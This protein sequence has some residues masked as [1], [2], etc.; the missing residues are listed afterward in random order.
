M[1]HDVGVVRRGFQGSLI[2]DIGFD[3]SRARVGRPR[4]DALIQ[5]R[6]PAPAG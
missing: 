1:E 2:A 4:L 6:D 3:H 5:E